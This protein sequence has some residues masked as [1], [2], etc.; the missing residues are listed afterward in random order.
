MDSLHLA[1]FHLTTS[2]SR[3]IQDAEE[4]GLPDSEDNN[5]QEH[6]ETCTRDTKDSVGTEQDAE[7]RI[8]LDLVPVRSFLHTSCGGKA[9]PAKETSRHSPVPVEDQRDSSSQM[10]EVGNRDLLQYICH[11]VFGAYYI[12]TKHIQYTK[13]CFIILNSTVCFNSI[14]YLFIPGN[15]N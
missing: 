8:Y 12:T 13:T 5:L 4:S 1:T 3:V 7:D 14:F 11:A 10:K 2:Y 15:F 9:L 6:D